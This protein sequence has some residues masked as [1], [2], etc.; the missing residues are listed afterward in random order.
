MI[1]ERHVNMK[2]KYGKRHF[3]CRGYYVNKVIMKGS[4]NL[5]E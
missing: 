2:Y 5:Q 4:R 1:F 3:W